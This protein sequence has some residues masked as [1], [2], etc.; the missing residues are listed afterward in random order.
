MIFTTRD[1]ASRGPLIGDRRSVRKFAWIP[2]E[3]DSWSEDPSVTRYVW[4]AMYTAH[5]RFGLMPWPNASV[6][7]KTVSRTLEVPNDQ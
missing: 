2:R 4:L 1:R 6:S 5:Q 7:W 3:L